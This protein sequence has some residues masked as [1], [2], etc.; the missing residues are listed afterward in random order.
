MNIKRHIPNFL[1]CC[2][3][4]CGTLGIIYCFDFY[5]WREFQNMDQVTLLSPAI[6][7]WAAGVFDF[8]DGFAAKMLNVSSAIGKELDSL[9]DVVS[10]GLLPAIFMYKLLEVYH[11]PL[12]L[13]LVPLLI[14]VFSAIRLAVFN[15]DTTQTDSFKGLPVPANA[16]FITGLPFV[17]APALAFIFTPIGLAIICLVFCFL[18]VSRLD[19]FA[20]KFKHFKWKANEVRF[21]FLILSVLLLAIWQVAALSLIIVLYILMSIG[22]AL[23][24]KKESEGI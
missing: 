24:R 21:T 23:V 20:L 10:F 19:L 3:L 13:E 8:F 14:V 5:E 2:N 1:T 9:A 22:I 16:I 11:H 15:I 18:L 6:F 12:H 17:Q 4:L 7:I